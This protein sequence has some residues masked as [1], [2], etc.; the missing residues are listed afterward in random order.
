MRKA[1]DDPTHFMPGNYTVSPG[2][3][4]IVAEIFYHYTPLLD[5]TGTLFWHMNPQTIYK[6]ALFKPRQGPLTTLNP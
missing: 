4:V 6:T 1:G 2:Q 3:N 5:I